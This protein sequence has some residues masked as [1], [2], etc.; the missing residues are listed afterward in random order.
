MN[1]FNSE[2]GV[3]K[4]ITES[5]KK[6]LL[7]NLADPVEAAAYLNAALED[8]SDDAFLMALRDIAEAKGEINGKV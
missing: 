6:G 4:R 3:I 8:D 7:K 5:Y 1:H 2:E